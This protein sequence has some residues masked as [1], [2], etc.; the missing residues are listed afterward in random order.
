MFSNTIYTVGIELDIYSILLV[1]ICRGIF[2]LD[3]SY[4]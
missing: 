3:M 4:I 2:L 1:G